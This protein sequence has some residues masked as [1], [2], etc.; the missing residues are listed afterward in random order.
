MSSYHSLGSHP[1]QLS[2]EGKNLESVK[3]A[4]LLGF[5]LHENLRWG[6]HINYLA[7]CCYGTLGSLRKIKNFT[8]YSLRKHLTES[9]VLSRLDF[10][11][12]IV[13]FPLME[14]LLN[15]LQRIQCCAA[16]FVI[17]QYVNSIESIVKL[18]WLPMRERREWYLLKTVHKALYSPD[19]A[20]P[21]KSDKVRHTR[22]LSSNST[23]NLVIPLVP[24]TFQNSAAALFNSLPTSLKEIPNAKSFS[25]AVY[26]HLKTRHSQ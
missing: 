11:D 9:L 13:F 5:R 20:K 15:R 23:L 19:C 3:S 10:S 1:P 16:S 7:S 2:V 24:N 4:K 21:I 25:K 22:I 14:R 18:G 12:T 6:D 8:T 17:G 26:D